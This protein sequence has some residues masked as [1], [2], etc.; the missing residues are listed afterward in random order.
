MTT[1]YSAHLAVSQGKYDAQATAVL[2]YDD[3]LRQTTMSLAWPVMPPESD[4]ENAG[5][6]LFRLLED[7]V[8]NFDAHQVLNAAHEPS[9][10][11]K[12]TPRA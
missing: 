4:P 11:A 1:Y 6:W 12:G 9:R 8:T 10:A 3:G 5:E 7:L 2:S